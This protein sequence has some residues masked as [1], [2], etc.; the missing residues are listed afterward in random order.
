MMA[1]AVPYFSFWALWAYTGNQLVD[2]ARP[3]IG[4]DAVSNSDFL[5]HV[6]LLNEGYDR[7]GAALVYGVVYPVIA[8][9]IFGVAY[10]VYRG[11]RPK[12]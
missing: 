7:L 8:L 5:F 11:F 9:I 10:W 4:N 12:P 3:Y 1:L 6:K 2:D